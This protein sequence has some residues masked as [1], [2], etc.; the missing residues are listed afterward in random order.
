MRRTE[1][2]GP[3][4]VL[5][6]LGHQITHHLTR[7]SATGRQPSHYLAVAAIETEQ[8][9]DRLAIPAANS[10]DIRAPAQ[11]ALERYHHAIVTALAPPTI[12]RQQQLIGP[13]DAVDSL[14]VDP[15]TTLRFELAIEQRGNPAIS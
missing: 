3:E 15:R 9:L 5:K 11:V 2:G 6:A 14:V 13:H 12:T 7:D 1:H 4:A 10:E 8:Y